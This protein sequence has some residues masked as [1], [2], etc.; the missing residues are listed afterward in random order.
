MARTG[1]PISA[2]A[3]LCARFGIADHGED[4]GRLDLVFPGRT[5]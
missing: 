2:E 4:L 3:E 1:T 5:T